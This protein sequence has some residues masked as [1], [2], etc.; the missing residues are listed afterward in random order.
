MKRAHVRPAERSIKTSDPRRIAEAGVRK[1][2]AAFEEWQWSFLNGVDDEEFDA[3]FSDVEKALMVEHQARHPKNQA[4][5][6]EFES[7]AAYIVGVQ[8]GLRLRGGAR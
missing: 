4:K 8:V 3:L 5:D 7:T 2:F 6:G 1:W